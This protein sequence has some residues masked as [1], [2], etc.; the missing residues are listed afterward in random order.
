MLLVTTSEA[1]SRS[2][3]AGVL[4]ES[5]T[6][7]QCAMLQV[8]SVKPLVLMGW[9]SVPSAI[10]RRSRD[11][12]L[13]T[14]SCMVAFAFL[15]ADPP[16]PMGPD[17]PLF[18][19]WNGKRSGAPPSLGPRKA[20]SLHARPREDGRTIQTGLFSPPAQMAMLILS[21][22]AGYAP[23]LMTPAAL[24][25]ARASVAYMMAEEPSKSF[26]A[27]ILETAKD[28][29]EEAF[30]KEAAELAAVARS[31]ETIAAQRALAGPRCSAAER[32]EGSCA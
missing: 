20:R 19:T 9:T 12:S 21:G 17:P 32:P 27:E 11:R 7:Q 31:P 29:E 30:A 1:L 22:P 23:A 5:E 3:W 2:S 14:S 18:A 6:P 13:V 24:A 28:E 26:S 16:A 4:V 15:S 10:R 25:P 8:R